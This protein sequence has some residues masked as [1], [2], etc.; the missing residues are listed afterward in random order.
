MRRFPA[1]YRMPVFYLLLIVAGGTAAFF[2]RGNTP[3]SP[4][5]SASPV[6]AV[7]SRDLLPS[8]SASA[9]HPTTS[10]PQP[11]VGVA[12]A[13]PADTIL[14]NDD[15][16][17]RKVLITTR[18]VFLRKT[19]DGEAVGDELPLFATRYVYAE[20]PTMYRVGA[21]PNGPDGWLSRDDAA[22]WDSRLV[23]RPTN[24]SS[25]PSIE[26]FGDQSCLAAAISGRVCPKHGGRCPSEVES[27]SDGATFPRFG[28]PIVRLTTVL[29]SDGLPRPVDEVIPLATETIPSDAERLAPLRQAL[30]HVYITFVMDTTASMKPNI[31]AARTL[32]NTLAKDVGKAFGDVTLHLG[33][34]E[35]RDDAPGLG[36]KAR[37]AT[38]FTDAVG[39]RGVINSLEPALHEDVTSGESVVEGLMLALP[40]TPGGLDWPS[41]RAGEL[42][43]KLIVLLGDA[44]DHTSDIDKLNA[45]A[46]RARG[47][48]ISIATV[49]LDQPKALSQAD[50]DRLETQWKALAEGAYRPPDRVS[51]FAKP[52][53]AIAV[54][55]DEASSL[56]SGLH[57]LVRDRV[58]HARWLAELARAEDE[59]SLD[60]YLRVRGLTR[61]QAAPVLEDLR[62][63]DPVPKRTR[64]RL[65][66]VSRGWLAER[67]GDTQFVTMGVLLSRDELDTLIARLN[68]AADNADE[69]RA[70]VNA[71]AAGE[72]DFLTADL[73]GLTAE[74]QVKRRKAFPAPPANAADIKTRISTAVEGLSGLRN[75]IRWSNAQ[76][77][78]DG[79]A[80]VSFDLMNF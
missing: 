62:R 26:M 66:S 37:V 32:A 29:G 58:E 8:Q 80:V 77:L 61:T 64:R 50:H 42:A 30:R 72:F 4:T 24:R 45:L 3:K 57:D 69:L 36:F 27:Q 22:G 47:A 67:M 6:V 71:A 9:N 31:E 46:A 52:L 43:T 73:R 10:T 49:A 38:P 17:R 15:G 59:G 44:P 23:A 11:A 19:A 16:L 34:V 54:R 53:P 63:G 28:W 18:N 39:F 25:R 76:E 20:S 2:L 55:L 21:T 40:G 41:G 12:E 35:Y 56:V 78:I 48:G 65:P 60:D 13:L 79:R 70:V 5:G 7:I 74:A 68:S 14:R 1:L 33:L 51:K 75:D